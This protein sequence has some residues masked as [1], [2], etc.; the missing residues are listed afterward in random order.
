MLEPDLRTAIVAMHAKKVAKHEIARIL[1]VS[2][3]TVKNIIKN[4]AAM[5]LTPRSDAITIAPELLVQLYNECSGWRERIWEKLKDEHQVDVGYSTLTRMIRQLGLGLK[6]RA[7]HVGDVP[8]GEMQH[9]TSPHRIKVGGKTVL[10]ITVTLYFRYSKQI[11]IRFYRSFNRFSMKSFF[12]EALTHYG[13]AAP[14]CIIDN[15]NLAVLRGTGHAAVMH[16][17][18]V[19]FARRYGFYFVAHELR[20]SNRKAGEERAFWTVETNFFP[21]RTFASMEDLN[22]QGHHWATELMANR[23]R[24]KSRLIPVKA[25][26]YETAFLKPVSAQLP[27]PYTPHD[28]KV[29]QYGFVAFDANSY[30][31]SSAAVGAVKVLQYAHEIKIYQGRRLLECFPLPPEGTR[32]K[33]YP[34]HR[35]HVAYRPRHLDKPSADE[36]AVLRQHSAAASSYLDFLLK[37]QGALRHR[38][39]RQLHSL[40]RRLSAV[41]FDRVIARA[42]RYG[43]SDVGSLEEIARLL[44]R[45]DA[46]FLP[47]VTCDGAY[48]QRQEYLEGRITDPPRLDPYQLYLEDDDE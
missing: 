1:G 5:R 10:V 8:G 42:H 4:G 38:T 17:E 46:E 34:E 25:F 7:V 2:R 20:H 48:E 27:P 39:L 30:W 3:N 16:P 14:E 36:E 45:E 18:M 37:G 28:R 19:A 21:G 15:T 31:I 32:N 33:I 23:V 22:A 24:A 44:A 26:E 13:Y 11:Y 12:H 29:D 43:V 6:P 47:D 40:Y 9:D 35:P 41:L